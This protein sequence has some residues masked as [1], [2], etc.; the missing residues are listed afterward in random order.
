MIA[1]GRAFLLYSQAREQ[2][3]RIPIEAKRFERKRSC[4]ADEPRALTPRTRHQHDRCKVPYPALPGSPLDG[5]VQFAPERTLLRISTVAPGLENAIKGRAA[6]KVKR[7]VADGARAPSSGATHVQGFIH[8]VDHAL[9]GRAG[10]RQGIPAAGRVADRGG[11]TRARSGRHHGREPDAEPRGAQARHRAVHQDGQEARAGDRRRR[12]QLHGRGHRLHPPRQEG[13]RRRG[14]ALHRLLQQADPGGPLSP[15][16]GDQR[17]GRHSDLRLQRAGAHHRR[18][19]GA[20]H[21]A[22]RQA[23]ACGRR[24]G[25]HRQRRARHAAA[26]RLRQE[27]RPALGRGRHR[28]RLHGAR[29]PRLHLGHL[30]RGAA[31]VRRSSRTPASRAT[32]RRRW[33]CRTG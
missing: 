11:H 29:R 8:G 17:G 10:R 19:P 4:C 24:Q 25:C 18:H 14:A 26:P 27:L 32:G 31:A 13:R 22:L 6:F 20:D 15:L 9:Q 30:Q 1:C 3:S 21:G 2:D 7:G 28:A 16:Q 23:R 5:I 33:S 12:L